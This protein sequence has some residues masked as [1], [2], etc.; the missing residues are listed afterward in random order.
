[1]TDNELIRIFLPIIQAGLA[2]VPQ[3]SNVVVKQSNQPTVQGANSV[4][5]VYFYKVGDPKRYGFLMREEK[6]TLT[7]KIRI[8]TQAYET[9]FNVS[10][11]VRQDPVNP[12]YTASD[13]VNYVSM[14]MG[15][16]DTIEKM[17]VFNVGILRIMDI[18]N[19]YFKDD[20]DQYEAAP[21]FSFTLTHFNQ[22]IIDV[23]II[24]SIEGK[25]IP[26]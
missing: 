13:L 24:D 9:S 20:R 17:M 21:A 26:V 3:Y 10:A 8:E 1:M 11:W 7:G 15:S 5:T 6:D 4:P 12:D 16:Q 23:N 19:P 18:D 22:R 25:I 2:A 14:I